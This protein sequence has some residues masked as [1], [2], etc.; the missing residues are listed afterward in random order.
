VLAADLPPVKRIFSCDS[1]PAAAKVVQGIGR[2]QQQLGMAP[3]PDAALQDAGRCSLRASLALTPRQIL[4]S[5]PDG[6]LSVYARQLLELRKDAADWNNFTAATYDLRARLKEYIWARRCTD[7][8]VE[9]G[10]KVVDKIQGYW[11]KED[12]C[13]LPYYA[14]VRDWRNLDGARG[15]FDVGMVDPEFTSA[16]FDNNPH[17]LDVEQTMDGDLL[18]AD[19]IDLRDR[20]RAARFYLLKKDGSSLASVAIEDIDFDRKKLRDVYNIPVYFNFDSK[21]NTMLVEFTNPNTSLGGMMQLHL[22]GTRFVLDSAGTKV[23]GKE[24]AVY[25]TAKDGF[26]DAAFGPPPLPKLPQEAKNDPDHIHAPAVPLPPLP[27]AEKSRLMALLS[28]EEKE[29]REGNAPSPPKPE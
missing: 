1:P 4:A 21:E 13:G 16:L 23:E 26:N 9:R 14:M 24:V 27:D 12:V 2:L 7:V 18:I 6:L 29:P 25:Y 5:Y 8:R 28:K 19:Y 22:E 11:K 3:P 17:L 15:K 20:P 10:D